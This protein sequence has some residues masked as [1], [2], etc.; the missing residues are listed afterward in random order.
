MNYNDEFDD[1]YDDDFNDEGLGLDAPE[2][3]DIPG[4][5]K[6][7]GNLDPLDI[8]NPVSAYFF[9]SDDV[10]DEIQTDG[11]KGIKCLSCGHRFVGETYDNCPKCFS[12]N[13]EEISNGIDNEIETDYKPKMKCLSCGHVFQGDITDDCP[14]CYNSDTEQFIRS[15]DEEDDYSV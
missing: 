1:D 15:I 8:T 6:S 2:P 9:L 10:Q 14:E 12:S 4:E 3:R 11:K 5:G 7:K 13:T